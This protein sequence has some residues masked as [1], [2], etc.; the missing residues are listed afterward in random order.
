M[1]GL[2]IFQQIIAL[3]NTQPATIT[4]PQQ[5]ATGYG[6][7]KT[8]DA[9]HVSAN[10]CFHSLRVALVLGTVLALLPLCPLEATVQVTADAWFFEINGDDGSYLA[11]QDV[12]DPK[13]LKSKKVVVGSASTFAPKEWG[14]CKDWREEQNDG[15][16][17]YWTTYMGEQFYRVR[18]APQTAEPPVKRRTEQMLVN[19][20]YAG[21]DSA[22]YFALAFR[23]RTL[24]HVAPGEPR[25]T[26]YIA[27]WHHGG[28]GPPAARLS[29]VAEDGQLYLQGGIWG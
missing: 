12:T 7:D 21:P 26:G 25:K 19:R 4:P 17:P 27:Q 1:H 14:G 2:Y 23:L 9:M 22:R 18:C 8:S 13:Y 20:W 3:N 6:T 28:N 29:W 15:D 24:P 11:S 5:F 10:A 16:L